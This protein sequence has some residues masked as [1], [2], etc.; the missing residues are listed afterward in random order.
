MLICNKYFLIYF[1]VAAAIPGLLSYYSEYYLSYDCR[2]S[3]I[4]IINLGP[5]K[6]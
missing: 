1:V 3:G 4:K 5:D 6:H 2:I